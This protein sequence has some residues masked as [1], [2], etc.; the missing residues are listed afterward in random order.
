MAENVHKLVDAVSDHVV[1]SRAVGNYAYAF[2]MWFHISLTTLTSF[3]LDDESLSSLTSLL[4]SSHRSQSRRAAASNLPA[5]MNRWGSRLPV[6]AVWD[7]GPHF[8]VSSTFDPASLIRSS[9]TRSSLPLS[10]SFHSTFLFRSKVS[11]LSSIRSSVPTSSSYVQVTTS[12][13]NFTLI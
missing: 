2:F 1:F 4:H 12:L 7:S 5:E 11:T 8:F 13:S 9:L 6:R 10:T 3:W